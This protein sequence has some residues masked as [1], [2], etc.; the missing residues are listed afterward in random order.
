MLDKRAA[1]IQK[2][3]LNESSESDEDSL[4]KDALEIEETIQQLREIV[5]SLFSEGIQTEGFVLRH[6]DLSRSN[7]MVDPITLEITGIIDW[8]CIS[9]A[10]AWEDTYPRML[11]GEDMEEQPEP[12]TFGE[13]DE[14]HVEEWEEWEEW[15]NTKL[16]KIFDQAAGSGA[17]ND[18]DGCDK[19]GFREQLDLLE[20]STKMVKDWIFEY[21]KRTREQGC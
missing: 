12:L 7:V 3:H 11:Q 18:R 20:F 13:T 14:F 19:R 1:G 9:T 15:E 6:H 21:E 17:N 8:E 10:P 4:V 5:P 16:R 2:A